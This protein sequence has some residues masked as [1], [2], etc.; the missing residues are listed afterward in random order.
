V[1]RPIEVRTP[2]P[3]MA[4]AAVAMTTVPPAKTTAAPD[5]P[6]ALATANTHDMPSLAGFWAGRDVELKREVGLI[7]SD[8][9]AEKQREARVGERRAI[10]ERLAADGALPAPEEPASPAELRGAVHEFLC[11]TPSA[12]VGFNLDDLVGEVEPVNLPGVPPDKFSSW[13]RK[14]AT[15]IEALAAAPEVKAALRCGARK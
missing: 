13:T 3:V 8:E 5:E 11:R 4:R 2:T 9:D 1:D 10:L 15:P 7:G 12:L 14:L 6:M